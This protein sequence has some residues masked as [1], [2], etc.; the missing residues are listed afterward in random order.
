M[1]TCDGR[2]RLLNA[3]GQMCPASCV[4]MCGALIKD[5]NLASLLL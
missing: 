4:E 2:D 5:A 3:F 1:M